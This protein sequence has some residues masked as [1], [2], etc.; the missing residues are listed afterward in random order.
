[1]ASHLI[2]IT[3]NNGGEGDLI[4]RGRY[5]INSYEDEG[6]EIANDGGVTEESCYGEGAENDQNPEQLLHNAHERL[7]Q[8]VPSYRV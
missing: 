3:D 2:L 7:A 6:G 4:Q 5:I 1:M 8:I